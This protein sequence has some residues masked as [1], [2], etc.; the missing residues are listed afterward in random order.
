MKVNLMYGQGDVLHTHLNIN[1]FAEEVVEGKIVRSDIKNLDRFLDDGELSE[2]VALDVIDYLPIVEIERI[3]Q[4]WTNKLKHGGRI[5][6]G[7]TDLFEVAKSLSQYRLDIAEANRL[8][9][10]SQAKPFMLKRISFSAVGLSTFLTE[11]FG[12]QILKKRINNYE[13]VIE[14]QRT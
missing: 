10:G 4:N 13:F 9:H 11:K 14:A 2:L 1:P 7:G 6:L 12:L 8:L 3:L 5:I